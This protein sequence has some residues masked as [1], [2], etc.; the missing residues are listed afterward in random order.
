VRARGAGPDIAIDMHGNH[1]RV[2]WGLAVAIALLPPAGARAQEAQ[3]PSEGIDLRLS[4]QVETRADTRV[5]AGEPGGPAVVRGGPP[6]ALTFRGVSLRLDTDAS[7]DDN[8]RRSERDE[9]ADFVLAVRPSVRVDAGWRKHRL[10]ASY[11][12][13]IGLFASETDESFFDNAL[14]GAVLLDLTRKL[15]VRLRSGIEF[16]HDPRGDV[17]ARLVQAAEPDRWRRTSYGTEVS[18]GRRVAQAQLIGSFDSASTRYT[19]NDQEFRDFDRIALTG[20][21]RWNFGP[22]LSALLRAR[23]ASFNYLSPLSSLDSVEDAWQVGVAW[24]ATAKTSG[25]YLMGFSRKRFE[26]A[27]Q[28]DFSGFSWE[29]RVRWE[30]KPYSIVTGSTSRRTAEASQAGASFL[31]SNTLR[32]D[33]RH[34]FTERLALETGGRFTLADFSDDREDTLLDLEAE[35]A[36][37]WRDWLALAVGYRF[38]ARS[39]SVAGADYTNNLFR[40]TVSTFFRRRPRR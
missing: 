13:D 31:V 26:D 20:T 8:V 9:I 39:S 4:D 19:N 12:G 21:A 30:P 11:R 29:S 1:R 33:W 16:G 15:D 35:L 18:Y 38:S 22:R 14:D 25:E 5:T 40:V 24:E 27:A 36:W 2:G 34:E 17:D 7:F 10:T 37:L 32:L 28:E 6:R 3:G 23:L